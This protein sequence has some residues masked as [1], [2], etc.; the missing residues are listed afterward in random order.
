MQDPCVK[1]Q[2]IY[3]ED[4]SDFEDVYPSYTI[5]K[6]MRGDS[7]LGPEQEPGLIES[8][9]SAF[10]AD[11]MPLNTGSTSINPGSSSSGVSF[12]SDYGF[13]IVRNR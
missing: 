9:L 12:I 7:Y 3:G 4:D 6:V 2:I 1:E 13:R 8:E 10:R 5:S 11:R